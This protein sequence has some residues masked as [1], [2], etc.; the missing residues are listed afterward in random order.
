MRESAEL[1]CRSLCLGERLGHKLGRRLLVG[2]ERLLCLRHHEDRVDQPLLSTVVQI[3]N[4]T[5]ALFVGRR[6]DPRA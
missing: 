2:L 6:H 4:D 5:P 1:F 3:A